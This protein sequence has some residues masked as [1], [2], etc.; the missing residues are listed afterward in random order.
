MCDTVAGYLWDD[1]ARLYIHFLLD[2]IVK[3]VYSVQRPFFVF[4]FFQ[5][6]SSNFRHE[7][8]LD[9]LKTDFLLKRIPNSEFGKG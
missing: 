6:K 3:R 2:S 7:K 1:L 9:I 4:S 5:I 8:R